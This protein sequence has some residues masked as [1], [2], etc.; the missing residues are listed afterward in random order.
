MK[1]KDVLSKI[2]ENKKNGQLNTGIRKNQL[3]RIGISQ[4]D[5]FNMNIE[6]KLKKLLFEG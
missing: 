1:L 6:P 4:E 3:K 2:V 5:L